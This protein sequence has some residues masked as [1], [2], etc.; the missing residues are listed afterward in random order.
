MPLISVVTAV[1]AGK[2]QFLGEVYK[3]LL[4]QRMPPDWDWQWIV[5][6]DGETGIPQ[7]ALPTDPRISA[8]SGPRS[9]ASAARTV[10]LSRVDGA[11]L[12]T[13]DADDLLPEGALY[14]DITTL[15]DHPTIGWCVSPTV[16]LVRDGSLR[17]GPRDPNPGPLPPGFLADGERAGMLQVHGM[18]LCTYAALVRTLGGWPALPM[19]EDVGL[20]LAAEAVAEGWMIQEPGLIYRRW[21]GNTTD[22]TDKRI[23]SVG[24]D[25]RTVLLDRADQLRA[26]GWRW[27]PPGVGQRPP[28]RAVQI[29]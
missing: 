6:E 25:L 29:T 22:E 26:I 2:H 4:G 11:L 10:A 28:S 20:L 5:Q 14:R 19:Q 7:A 23:P 21:S 15:I 1:L 18:T 3:S 12:R 17:S 13:V 27:R 16:D 9:R 24:N 8:G